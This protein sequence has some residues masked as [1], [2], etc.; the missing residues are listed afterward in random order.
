MKEKKKIVGV[1]FD[2]CFEDSVKKIGKSLLSHR[3]FI[4]IL[5]SSYFVIKMDLTLTDLELRFD[6]FVLSNRVWTMNL[7]IKESLYKKLVEEARISGLKTG[8]LVR[9]IIILY[10]SNNGFISKISPVIN[11][12]LSF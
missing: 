6:N 12:V 10:L 9:K 5:I 2:K 7:P 1:R 3:D 8:Q 11:K 4:Q